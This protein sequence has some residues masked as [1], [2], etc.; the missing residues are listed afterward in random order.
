MQLGITSL[1]SEGNFLN[2]SF[3]GE[4]TMDTMV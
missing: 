4:D 3:T 2:F 1:V